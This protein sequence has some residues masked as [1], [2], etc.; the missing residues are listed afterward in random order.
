M[1]KIDLKS[2]QQPL[3]RQY[4]ASPETAMVVDQ[5]STQ[6]IDP[7]DPFHFSVTPMRGSS[8]KIPVGVHH[9][10]GGLHDAPTPGDILCAALA[11]CQES[12]IRLIAN[13]LGIELEHIE[14]KVTG[15]V[16]VRGTLVVDRNVPVGFQQMNCDIKLRVKSGTSER[17]LQKLEYASQYSCVV[18]QT[19]LTP[20]DIRTRFKLEH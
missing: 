12:T 8:V 1:S 17:L 4:I 10:V 20:P 15:N 2:I 5:A 11:A 7:G 19:L 14:V 9:A 6:G 16:D 13:L 3:C 18:Q